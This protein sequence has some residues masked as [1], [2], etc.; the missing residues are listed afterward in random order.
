MRRLLLLLQQAIAKGFAKAAQCD[1]LVLLPFILLE[2]IIIGVRLQLLQLLAQM[3]RRFALTISGGIEAAL[4]GTAALTR[5]AMHAGRISS[6]ARL[7]PV[8]VLVTAALLLVQKVEG[9]RMC[10]IVQ[11]AIAIAAPLVVRVRGRVTGMMLVAGHLL[12]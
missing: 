10:I 9:I 11:H 12:R 7:C 3:R 4:A 5:L 1:C 8:P 6:R 2:Q